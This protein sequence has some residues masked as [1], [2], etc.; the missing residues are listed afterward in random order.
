[1]EEGERANRPIMSRVW[2]FMIFWRFPTIY[3]KSLFCR[4]EHVSDVMVIINVLFSL[5]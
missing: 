4:N 1:M 2:K 5:T 3:E